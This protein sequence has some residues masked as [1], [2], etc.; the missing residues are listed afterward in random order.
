MSSSADSSLSAR[1]LEAEEWLRQVYHGGCPCASSL[2]ARA[3]C[4]CVRA[5]VRACLPVCVCVRVRAQDV[6]DATGASQ[7][8]HLLDCESGCVA[9]AGIGGEGML[10]KKKRN[11]IVSNN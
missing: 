8:R 1:C 6:I 11:L 2:Y 9:T 5:C 10:L 3:V 7:R 4:M